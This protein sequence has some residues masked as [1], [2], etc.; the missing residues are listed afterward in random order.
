M[1]VHVSKSERRKNRTLNTLL[2]AVPITMLAVGIN[3]NYLFN[4]NGNSKNP[5]TDNAINYKEGYYQGYF[6]RA[7]EGEKYNHISL[8]M[9]EKENSLIKGADLDKD[10]KFDTIW[11]NEFLISKDEAEKLAKAS[12]DKFMK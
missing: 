9:D 3:W 8:S 7:V 5:E 12:Y 10:G 1:K 6:V 4:K 2:W 11:Y